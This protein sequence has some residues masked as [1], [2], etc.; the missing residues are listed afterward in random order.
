M[1]MPNFI[2]I[3]AAKSGTTSL[4]HYLNQHAQIYMSPMKETNFF[5]YE[6]KQHL[7]FPGYGPPPQT[8]LDSI[9]DRAAYEAQFTGVRQE[10]ALGEASVLYLYHE[11]AP[12]RIQRTIPSAKLI[13]VL[14]H[15]AD[16]AYSHYLHLIRD[17]REPLTDFA[18]ALAAEP[19]RRAAG[20]SW[21]YYYRDMGFYG[22]QLE[23]YY[24]LFD[25]AQI[26]VFLYDDLK[27][28]A[29]SLVQEILRF[30]GVS[31]DFR[32]DVSFRHNV[33]GVPQNEAIHGLLHRP[34]LLKR[35]V[36]PFIPERLRRRVVTRLRDQALAKPEMAPAVRQDLIAG[37]R[38][39]IL[40]LQRLI[41]RDLSSWL[42]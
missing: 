29:T 25:P 9:T 37:Y 13:A 30:L 11:E 2:I 6:G 10:K 14:R 19:E 40:H 12:G 27:R 5:A 23:R 4:Y 36:R 1:T 20:W 33:S 34:N 31:D 18:A 15:P 28:D 7:H 32:P 8:L 39:D 17:G 38:E 41:D 22:A 26:K 24:N 16:R 35:I 21:D 42:T 3:G